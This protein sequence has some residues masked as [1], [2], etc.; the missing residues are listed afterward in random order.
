MILEERVKV[1]VQLGRFLKD[2]PEEEFKTIAERAKIDNQWFSEENVRMAVRGISYFLD[3][4]KIKSW[5]S[6]YSIQDH[7]AKTVA[8][9][10]AGNIP[11]VGFHDLLCVLLNGDAALIKASSKDSVLMRWITDKLTS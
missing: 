8:L 11:L 9:I 1:F 7:K 6:H 4:K 5:L 3:E 10:L 2:L